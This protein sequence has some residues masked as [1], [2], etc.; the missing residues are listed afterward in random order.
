[1][2]ASKVCAAC[3]YGFAYPAVFVA[4]ERNLFKRKYEELES[5]S[6]VKQHL[7]KNLVYGSLIAISFI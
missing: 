6:Q 4:A 1:V 2:K 7:F 5:Q 3:M